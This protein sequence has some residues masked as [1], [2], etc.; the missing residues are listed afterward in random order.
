MK[1]TTLK[2]VSNQLKSCL[3]LLY[4]LNKLRT[5]IIIVYVNDTLVIEDE[6][7][8]LYTLE[9]IKKEFNIQSIA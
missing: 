5:K 6:M 8:S 1:G 3:F 4:I 9:Y 7:V 2:A